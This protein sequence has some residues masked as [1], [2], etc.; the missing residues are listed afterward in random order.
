M[1]TR[2]IV[3]QEILTALESGVCVWDIPFVRLGHKNYCSGK[4]YNG[5]NRLIL[6]IGT[7]YQSNYWLTFNQAKEQGGIVKKG[8]KGT[9]IVFWNWFY[10]NDKGVIVK[11]PSDEQIDNLESRASVKYYT[12]FNTE[13]VENLPIKID[14]KLNIFAPVQKA[15]E[16]IN[17]Y[18]DCTIEHVAKNKN[19]YNLLTNIITL[20]PKDTFKSETQYYTT[21]FHELIHSTAKRLNRIK[22]DDCSLDKAERG[23][24]ELTAEIGA[25]MLCA[26]SG[27]KESVISNVS[28]YC[29]SWLK[30][31]KAD[32]NMLITASYRAEKAVNYILTGTK[33]CVENNELAIAV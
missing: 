14:K 4:M 7:K 33:D 22:D 29:N 23:L 17:G 12:V 1:D 15:E 21:V 6:N 18:K 32:K 27:F 16:V 2:S 31:I 28:S 24:E 3:V 5:I 8:E 9:K 10:I 26:Y 19:C 25:G 11:N 30:A 13:Q 20:S